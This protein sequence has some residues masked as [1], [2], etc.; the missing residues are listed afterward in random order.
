MKKQ[1]INISKATIWIQIIWLIIVGFYVFQVNTTST[2]WY[3]LKDLQE[4]RDILLT[5]QEDLNL[6]LS[7]AQ[8]LDT[9]KNDESIKIMISYQ[10]NPLY[11]KTNKELASKK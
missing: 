3:I 4:K 7:R 10:K 1:N 8:S 6:K 5:S 11:V 2:N 9:L